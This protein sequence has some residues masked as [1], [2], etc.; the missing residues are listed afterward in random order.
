MKTNHGTFRKFIRN[1]EDVARNKDDLDTDDYMMTED[2]YMIA[3]IFYNLKGYD[4]HLILYVTRQYVPNSIDVIPSTSKK[5]VS[6]Q[7]GRTSLPRQ[8]A[9]SHRLP[10]HAGPKFGCGWPR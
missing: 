9:I 6:F 1:A 5:F 4:S 2:S 10:R 8:F 7:I 3:V